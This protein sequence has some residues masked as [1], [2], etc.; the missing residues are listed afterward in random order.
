VAAFREGLAAAERAGSR[1]E[2][3][4]ALE[5]AVGLYQGELL[6][7]SYEEWVLREREWLA[8]QQFQA[9]CQ[10]IGYLEGA[11]DVTRALEH[12]RQGVRA[13]PLREEGHRELIRLLVAAGQPEAARRQYAELERLLREELGES[14]SA[15]TRALLA[16][17]GDGARGRRGDEAIPDRAKPLKEPATEHKSMLPLAPTPPL[18]VAPSGSL[19]SGT[20]TFL[21]TDLERSTALW[22]RAGEAVAGALAAHHA[23][24]REHFRQH[25]GREVKE[26]GDGFLVAFERAGDALACAIAGQRALAAHS[27]PEEV[28]PLRAR[29]AL[30]TGDVQ[31][32]ANDYHGP[33]LN[34]LSRILVAGHGGQIL[35]SEA[36]AVLLRRDLEPGVRLRDL[37]V[38]RLR[39]VAVPERLFQVEDPRAAIHE[40]PPLRAEAGHAGHLPPSFSRFFGREVEVERL[41]KT[42]LSVEGRLVT[43]M[44]PGGSGKTRLALE[45]A[46]RLL[47]E[48]QGA[49][50][51]VPL[52][53]LVEAERMG[54]AVRDAMR[55]PHAPQR[56]PLEQALEALA[57]QPSLLILDNFEQL[58]DEGAPL[59]RRLLEGAPS[60]TCL[61]TSRRRLN[62][63]GEREFVVPTLPVPDDGFRLT[64]DSERQPQELGRKGNRRPPSQLATVNWQLLTEV[65]SVQLFVDRAQAVR[66]DFQVTER[67]AAA[68]AALCHRLE[69]I[70]LAIELAA[71]RA[72]VLT[73]AQMVEHLSRRFQLLVGRQRDA[74]GRHR[75]LRAALDWSYDLL[76]PELQRFF[77]RL[78]VFRGGWE[79]AAVEVVCDEPLALDYL[80]Q[81]RECSLVLAEEAGDAR[82]EIRFRMLETLRE[83]AGEQLEADER[84]DLERQHT[85]YYLGLAE[86][87]E[88]QLAGSEQ[89]EWLERLETEHDNL[90][91]VLDR[92]V[93]SGDAETGLRLGGALLRFWER[94]GHWQ[95]GLERLTRVLAL[96]RAGTGTASRSM[97]LISAGTLARDQGE[98]TAARAFFEEGLAIARQQGDR[99]GVAK[100]LNGI[101]AIAVDQGELRTARELF[102]ESLAIRRELGDTLGISASLNNLGVVASELGDREAARAFHEESLRIKQELGDWNGVAISLNALGL[103]AQWRGDYR[104]ARRFAEESLAIRRELGDRDGTAYALFALGNMAEDQG[105]LE[106][107]RAL[108]EECLGIFRDVCHREGVRNALYHLGILANAA[109]EDERGEAL[110]REAVA[111]SEEMGD[112]RNAAAIRSS[113]GV[114]ARKRNDHATARAILEECLEVR[115]ELGDQD[116]IAYNL[117]ELGLLARLEGDLEAAEACHRESLTLRRPLGG[118]P[119]TAACLE[120]LATL[121]SEQG[122]PERAARLLGAA[123]ALRDVAGTPIPLRD[124]ADYERDLA[125]VRAALGDEAMALAWEAGKALDREQAIA[126]AL[127]E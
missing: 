77:A 122:R 29:L 55:L 20:V 2:R 127:E 5:E 115:R 73:P 76:S 56:E 32:E 24:L 124:R 70:P 87:A 100:A 67:N 53:D 98:L 69:G 59:V 30:H 39:D 125:A 40:F 80:S 84:A 35:C 71:A 52:A 113:L 6:P 47:E 89:G 86:E 75:T 90:R 126:L 15:E 60:L 9:L 19:P 12:A 11:G 48:W 94:R 61:V 99:Q 78:S 107:A 18:P 14:P 36:T 26:L 46:R 111:L 101:A 65:P 58:A 44:G 114:L 109:G 54:E 16:S 92:A 1:T 50:W 45:V 4:A 105:D 43:L 97:A 88:P 8:Q 37:G 74:A 31:V 62:L 57:R 13:D 106:T 116:G 83:Y 110:L 27:W 28:G 112:R 63:E 82:D 17:L 64:V 7:G 120:A 72:Q 22:E 25:R 34:C 41:S 85:A 93:A 23:L 21:M 3:V 96:D 123:A 102:E 91:A 118:T 42:L 117:D 10:L 95:E 49:V 108:Y 121:A 103:L 81:L 51:F 119:N 68:V 66:P 33:V 79:L 104:E 38:Y